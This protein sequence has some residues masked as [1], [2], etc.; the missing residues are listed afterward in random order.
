[1]SIMNLNK[2]WRKRTEDNR[3][4]MILDVSA[5]FLVFLVFT[6]AL[7]HQE[8]ENSKPMTVDAFAFQSSTKA[9]RFWI[10]RSGYFTRQHWK[11]NGSSS[12]DDDMDDETLL[13]TVTKTTLQ[14]LCKQY[15]VSIEGTK[16]ELLQRLRS[17]AEEQARLNKEEKSK[18]NERIE[19]GLKSDQGKAKYRLVDSENI[20]EDDTDDLEGV[21]FYQLPA[22]VEKKDQSKQKYKKTTIETKNPITVPPPPPSDTVPTSS[23]GERVVTVYSSSDQNDLTGVD[24]SAASSLGGAN[25]A[26]MGGYRQQGFGGSNIPENTLAGGPFGDSSGS[27]RKKKKS[28][29]VDAAKEDVINL[30]RSLLAMTGA[31]A[32]NDEISDEFSSLQNDMGDHSNSVKIET[33]NSNFVGFDPDR[34]PIDLLTKSSKALRIEDGATLEEVLSEFEIQAIGHDGISAPDDRSRGGGHYIEVQKVRAFLEGYRKA[35]TKR[36]ARETLTM[37]LDKLVTDGVKG[38]DEMLMVMTKD[39]STSSKVGELN[40]S[41]IQHLNDAIRQQERKVE[42]IQGSGMATKQQK[43]SQTEYKENIVSSLNDLWNITTDESGNIIEESIDP[44]D[45]RVKQFIQSELA[46]NGRDSALVSPKNPTL[47][48]AEQLLILLCLLRDRLKA[49]A[50]FEANE[51]GKNLRVLAYCLYGKDDDIER[52]VLENLG[53]SLSMLDTFSEFLI[54]SIDYAEST[55][56]QLAPSNKNILDLPRLKKIQQKVDD[57][58]ERISWKASGISPQKSM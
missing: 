34:V 52:I 32:F 9:P 8:V 22:K 30:V 20:D 1:M 46:G 10:D 28:T 42:L 47:H 33:S 15:N 50:V 41:L 37:L 27:L 21:F 2:L 38:L 13:K 6:K 51:Q 53:S 26:M 4:N 7:Y 31:P 19:A 54:S 12:S 57:I 35:E 43:Q 14:E 49:E 16:E 45:D 24:A 56:H 44:N 23:N 40:D 18:Q 3:T 36:V 58:K 5:I 25:H 48:P 39:D 55:S 17:F 11:L 29:D